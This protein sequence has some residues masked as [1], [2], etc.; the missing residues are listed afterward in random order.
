LVQDRLEVERAGIVA[1]EAKRIE[2]QFQNRLDAARRD[3]E[4]Q[5]AKIAQMERAELELRRKST[6]LDQQKRQ[7]ELTVTRQL[8]EEREAIR[9]E[10]MIQE[11][12]R[13][14]SA[15]KSEADRSRLKLAEKDKTI[16]DMRKQVE[17]L[18]RKSYQGSQQL[19]GEV[20]ERELEAIL[21]SQFPH[22]EF[23]AMQWGGLVET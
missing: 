20:Q 4:A 13:S 10:A 22:D 16:D 2:G 23:E 19:Q 15:Q 5:E 14:Q 9:R 11:Q 1:V 17:E 12:T 8:D 18:R 7:L 3:Q 21:R 6:A